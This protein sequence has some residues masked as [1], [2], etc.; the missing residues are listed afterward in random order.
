MKRVKITNIR[1]YGPMMC[2]VDGCI[3]NKNIEISHG[4]GKLLFIQ[5]DEPKSRERVKRERGRE[6][7]REKERE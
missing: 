6:V 1:S 4:G 7:H 3:R 2:F 5:R